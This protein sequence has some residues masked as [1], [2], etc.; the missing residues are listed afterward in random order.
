MGAYASTVLLVTVAYSLL[1]TVAAS[2]RSG[3]AVSGVR[4][5]VKCITIG[6]PKVGMLP[7]I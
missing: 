3:K 4:C 5:N 2:S 7:Q 6:E 1:A